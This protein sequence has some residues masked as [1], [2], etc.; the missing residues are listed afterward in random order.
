MGGNSGEL[1][2][3]LRETAWAVF[4]ITFLTYGT[5][6]TCTLVAANR[7]IFQP[8]KPSYSDTP[9]VLK[10]T[11][12][13]GVRISAIHLQNPQAVYTV[14]YSHGNAEDI[15]DARPRLTTIRD[16]GFNVFAYDYHGYGTSGGRPSE[17]NA[18]R[19]ID[20]AYDYLTVQLNIP[21]QR[22]ILHGYS[23]GSG[24]AVDLAARRP[25]AG[26]ILESPFTTAFRVVTRIPL[27]PCDRFRNIDKIGRI[28]CPLLILHGTS[29]QV[30]PFRHGKILFR[31]AHE[32]KRFFPVEGAN[33]FDLV[34]VAGGRYAEML[35][36]FAD[37]VG[38][39]GKP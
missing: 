13:E 37:L 23:V 34:Q 21:P 16:A 39:G 1:W 8:P 11:T 18:Y 10:I 25:V 32:P 29:D 31:A 33:H 28:G 5:I 2:I 9:E 14:I 6:F 19:D 3:F 4:R 15:G 17:L 24:P 12:A 38:A 35:K 36:D 27:F 20:A 22:I 30:I 7:M 26:L